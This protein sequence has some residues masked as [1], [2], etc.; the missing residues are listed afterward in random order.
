MVNSCCIR[1]VSVLITH[2]SKSPVTLPNVPPTFYPRSI[3]FFALVPYSTRLRNDILVPVEIK[4]SVAYL[5]LAINGLHKNE[6]LLLFIISPI[7]I[8]SVIDICCL[9][10]NII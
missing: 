5:D 1:L 9:N 2:P 8:I 6:K 10:L 7:I 4:A 3:A